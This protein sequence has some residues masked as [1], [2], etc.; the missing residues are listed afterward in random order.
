MAR[1]GRAGWWRSAWVAHAGASAAS[2]SGASGRSP[3]MGALP[4]PGGLPG[5]LLARGRHGWAYSWCPQGGRPVPPG[6]LHARPR[7]PGKADTRRLPVC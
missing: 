5:A 7:V 1:G 3:R 4:R 6:S 2:R